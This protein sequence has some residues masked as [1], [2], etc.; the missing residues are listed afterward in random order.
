MLDYP[1][2]L[3]VNASIHKWRMLI[4]NPMFYERLDD[5]GSCALCQ[6]F[7]APEGDYDDECFDCP[8]ALAVG[9]NHCGLTPYSPATWALDK[10]NNGVAAKGDVIAYVL[11][12]FDFLCSLLDQPIR[13]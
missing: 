11:E 4:E 7:L 10:I 6:K 8:V 12:E 9:D 5:I 3:A 1:T 2:A 13:D